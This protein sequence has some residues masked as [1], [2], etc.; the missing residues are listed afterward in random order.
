MK[1]CLLRWVAVAVVGLAFSKSSC[2]AEPASFDENNA[3]ISELV[4]YY[5]HNVCLGIGGNLDITIF[6]RKLPKLMVF[7]LS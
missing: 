5:I 4:E 7:R 3:T 1:R 2:S 6:E